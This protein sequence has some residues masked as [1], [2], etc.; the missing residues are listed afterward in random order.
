MSHHAA[1][2]VLPPLAS[3]IRFV[4]E[5]VDIFSLKLTLFCGVP[6]TDLLTVPA[7][8]PHVTNPANRINE[9]ENSAYRAITGGASS[10]SSFRNPFEGAVLVP[11]K[12]NWARR[13][14]EH[15]QQTTPE[16]H[17][18]SSEPPLI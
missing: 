14:T 3:T 18:Q 17:V 9:S 1:T 13:P 5:S 4:I 11:R 16:H 7:A 10:E 12:A 6:D 8:R 15:V 2:P